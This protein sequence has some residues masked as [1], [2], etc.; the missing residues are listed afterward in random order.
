[1]VYVVG[2]V[3]TVT[4]RSWVTENK[5]LFVFESVHL[6]LKEARWLRDSVFIFSQAYRKLAKEYH[7]DKN[8]NAGDKVTRQQMLSR[9]LT[10]TML[11]C[12]PNWN[13]GSFQ[14]SEMPFDINVL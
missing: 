1:M 13:A 10:F 11:T 8:P 9:E 5:C 3:L 6:C 7:P 14:I 12:V 2:D 4:L